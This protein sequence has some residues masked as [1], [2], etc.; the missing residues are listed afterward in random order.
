MPKR[1][2]QTSLLNALYPNHIFKMYF[3]YKNKLDYQY[4]TGSYNFSAAAFKKNAENLLVIHDKTVAEQYIA[5][6]QN[7]WDR[8]LKP[9][10]ADLIKRQQ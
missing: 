10:P 1:L 2:Y 3:Y 6:W 5:N 8:S 9:S 7:R 4:K